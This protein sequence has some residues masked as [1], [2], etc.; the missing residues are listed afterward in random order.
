MC[1]THFEVQ[2]VETIDVDVT[3]GSQKCQTFVSIMEMKKGFM[4]HL[5]AQTFQEL[6]LVS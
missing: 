1:S 4:L 3:L 2:I 5:W 6:G